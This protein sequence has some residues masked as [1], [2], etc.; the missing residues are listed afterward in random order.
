MKWNKEREKEE[1]LTATG[2]RVEGRDARAGGAQL[3]G[4]GALGAQLEGDLAREVLALELLVGAQVRQHHAR[5]AA[6]VGE[7]GE[8]LVLGAGVVGDGREVLEALL[9]DRLDERF[10]SRVSVSTSNSS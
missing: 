6:V 3:L 1:Q 4:Q 9:V 7:Q 8:T 2:R 5:D 10:F